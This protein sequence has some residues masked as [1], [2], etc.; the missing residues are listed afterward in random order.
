MNAARLASASSPVCSP[1][2]SQEDGPAKLPLRG[3]S[4]EAILDAAEAVVLASGAAHLTLDAVAERAGVSKGGL[5]YNFPS[6]ESLLQAMVDRNMHRLGQDHAAALAQLPPAPGRELTAFVHMIAQ[7][8]TC[9]EKRLGGS[10][11]AA[12]ANNPKLLE[13]VHRFHRWRLETIEAAARDGLPF[14]RAAIAS[15]A[16]DGLCLLE[17]LGL[18]PF[19]PE[20]RALILEDLQRFIDEMAS[21]C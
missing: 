10:L 6:K 21:A 5:L 13:P 9:C 18:S 17:M 19:A 15:L 2:V 11:L 16:L 7:K 14:E 8:S 4:R 20:Q 1:G 12:C 3:S